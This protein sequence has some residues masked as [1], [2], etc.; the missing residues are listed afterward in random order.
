MP[1]RLWLGPLVA[2]ASAPSVAH[3]D[4]PVVAVFEIVDARE[5]APLAVEEDDGKTM[6]GQVRR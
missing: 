3:A 1:S 5:A 4:A 6:K 2:L